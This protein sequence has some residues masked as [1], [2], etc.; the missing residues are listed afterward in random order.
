MTSFLC[1]ILNFY[2]CKTLELLFSAACPIEFPYAFDYAYYRDSCS[3]AI[4]W[5]P[6][7]PA[8]SEPP[9]IDEN[10]NELPIMNRR[11]TMGL[12]QKVGVIKCPHF[13]TPCT[14][15]AGILSTLTIVIVRTAAI[16]FT[17]I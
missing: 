4:L 16:L 15:T 11:P 14:D 7:D 2:I 13:P 5:N 9:E 6:N 12:E 8:P 3:D 17:F 1:L 10:G